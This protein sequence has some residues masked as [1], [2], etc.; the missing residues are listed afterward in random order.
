MTAIQDIAHAICPSAIL[1]AYERSGRVFIAS[2]S[3]YPNGDHIC[4]Y[5]DDAPA[6]A[7]FSDR[8]F[9]L[10]SLLDA[11]VELSAHRWNTIRYILASHDM[12]LHENT[13]RMPIVGEAFAPAF[14]AF[15]DAI[16]RISTLEFEHQPQLRSLYQPKVDFVLRRRLEP[17]FKIDRK[18]YDPKLDPDHLYPVHWALFAQR[19]RKHV[20]LIAGHDSSLLMPATVHFFASHGIKAPTLALVAPGLQLR[21]RQ[22]SRIQHV[23]QELLFQDIEQNEDRVVQWAQQAA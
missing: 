18:Y 8:G 11:G 5:L 15:C 17:Q 7:A 20:F 19:K 2:T 16:G 13:L 23:A 1:G 22:I 10:R 9:T 4:A 14:A 21:P 12:L 6:G 3:Q